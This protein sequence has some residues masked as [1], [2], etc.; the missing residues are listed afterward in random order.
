MSL[1]SNGYILVHPASSDWTTCTEVGHLFPWF[2]R[3]KHNQIKTLLN[4]GPGKAV[5]VSEF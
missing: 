1:Y 4:M 5:P 3:L 2:V